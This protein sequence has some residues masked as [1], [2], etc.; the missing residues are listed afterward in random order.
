M[1]NALTNWL[2]PSLMHAVA[3]T[4][5]HFL[6][7]GAALAA[8]AAAAMAFCSRASAR[9][10]IALSALMLM[11]AA[12]VVTLVVLSQNQSN[13]DSASSAIVKS[14]LTF[15][16]AGYRDAGAVDSLAPRVLSAIS[17]VLGFAFPWLIEAWLAGVAFFSLRSAGGFLLFESRS[18]ANCPTN[19]EPPACSECARRSNAVSV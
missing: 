11:L 4:L 1:M 12:P 17:L 8:L 13:D 9:Y 18:A 14:N 10:A 15:D 6:W 19:C 16:L 5:L 2:S 7:Q 3:W